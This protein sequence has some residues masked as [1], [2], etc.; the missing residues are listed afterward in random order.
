MQSGEKLA[1]PNFDARRELAA[2]I[3]FDSLTQPFADARGATDARQVVMGAEEFDIHLKISTNPS[4]HQIV[5]QVFARNEKQF[6]NSIRLHLLLDGEPF[7][8][9]WSDNF[10]QFHFD[11]V[12]A[13]VFRLQ[14]CLPQLTIVGGITIDEQT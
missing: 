5:G 14:I 3:V 9:A 13:G 10:G 12:P 7:Q 8:T 11:D 2:A 4:Q 6:L 1:E